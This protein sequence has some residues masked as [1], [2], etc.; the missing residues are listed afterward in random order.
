MT[1]INIIDANTGN[2][3]ELSIQPPAVGIAGNVHAPAADTAAVITKSAPTGTNVNVLGGVFWSYDADPTGGNLKIENGS[4]TTVFSI[5]ITTGGAGFFPFDPPMKG[6][7]E[8]ALIITLA[9]GGGAVSGKVSVNAWT[10]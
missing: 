10:E 4:G 2:L 3:V 8:T 1:K 5:D 7:V 6:D 9:A